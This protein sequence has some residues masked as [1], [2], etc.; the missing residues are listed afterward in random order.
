MILL[1]GDHRA[2]VKKFLVQTGIP[3]GSIEIH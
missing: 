3:E 2:K 1:Q